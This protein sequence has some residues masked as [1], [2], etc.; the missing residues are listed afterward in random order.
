MTSSSTSPCAGTT[1]APASRRRLARSAA[2]HPTS[3]RPS[4]TASDAPTSARTML[5][6]NASARTCATTSP[7]SGPSVG[8]DHDRSCSSRIVVAPGRGLQNAAKSRTPSRGRTAASIAATSSGRRFHS[9]HSR[10]SGSRC[11][12]SSATR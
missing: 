2:G 4:P 1:P 7:A 10:R 6:Q 8:R 3:R 11:A 12:G 5:W 9:T